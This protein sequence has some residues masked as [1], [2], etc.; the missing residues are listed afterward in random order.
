MNS[1]FYKK[2]ATGMVALA[3]LATAANAADDCVRYKNCKFD[4]DTTT[5]VIYAEN[6]Q[7]LTQVHNL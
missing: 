6:V 7:Q 5:N 1:Y 4:V 2:M 3:A